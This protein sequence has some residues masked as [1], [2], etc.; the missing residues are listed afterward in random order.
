M[1]GD[2]KFILEV[3]KKKIDI[4]REI[5]QNN[6]NLYVN[7]SIEKGNDIYI[8]FTSDIYKYDNRK[9]KVSI[10]KYSRGS[11]K[12]K[13]IKSINFDYNEN[14]DI[15]ENFI[16]DGNS[17]IIVR[18]NTKTID[19]FLYKYNI[20]DNL[21]KD[22]HYKNIKNDQ[23]NFLNMSI[24]KYLIY[25]KKENK[26]YVVKI[27]KDRYYL[28]VY[29]NDEDFTLYKKSELNINY[30][31]IEKSKKLKNTDYNSSV[32]F[33]YQ[34]IKFKNNL[35]IK[36]Q[37]DIYYYTESEKVNGR[38]KNFIDTHKLIYVYNIDKNKFTYI[39]ELKGNKINIY[40]SELIK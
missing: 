17:F 20:N 31:P 37:V 13:I 12:F 7:S 19:T 11:E 33:D 39:G 14:K 30:A 18:E 8:I 27:V 3:D 9:S 29:N 16:N 21:F 28:C 40:V 23:F 24:N 5:F 32:K 34:F 38:D 1:V 6:G 22:T 10:V 25:D 26:F 4:P 15:A 36:Q 35:V 2:N